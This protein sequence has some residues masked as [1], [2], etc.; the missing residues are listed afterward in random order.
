MCLGCLVGTLQGGLLNVLSSQIHR[1]NWSDRHTTGTADPS[2]GY[3]LSG[4]RAAP[5]KR[6]SGRLNPRQDA[7][8]LNLHSFPCLCKPGVA[9]PPSYPSLMPFPERI[10][11]Q[12]PFSFGLSLISKKVAGGSGWL[13]PT[14]TQAPRPWRWEQSSCLF[15][16]MSGTEFIVVQNQSTLQSGCMPI[17]QGS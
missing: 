12:Q 11:L 14:P 3:N 13:C 6:G 9:H 7:C 2:Q 15:C 8:S 4:T 1:R 5:R 17:F 10:H 16:F